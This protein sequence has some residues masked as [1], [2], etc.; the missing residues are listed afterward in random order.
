MSS[1]DVQTLVLVSALVFVLLGVMFFI[2]RTQDRS[3][4]GLGCWGSAFLLAA[5]GIVLLALRGKAP[6]WATQTLANSIL[7]LGHGLLYVGIRAFDGHRT[8]SWVVVASPLVWI[9]LCFSPGFNEDFGLRI[10]VFAFLAG[11]LQGA[12]ALSLGHERHRDPLP[13]RRITTIAFIVLTLTHTG[14]AILAGVLQVP[15]HFADIGSSWL[16]MAAVVMLLE[17]ILTGYLLLSLAKERA[18]ARHRREAE[19]D[20]LTGA[21]TRRAF[22]AEATRRLHADPDRGA[23]L[24]FDLDRFKAI[25]DTHGHAVGDRVL[26][27]FADLVHG[28]IRPADLFGRWGGEEFVLLLAEADFVGAHRT[29]EEIRR[30]FAALD[31]TDGVRSIGATVS[32]GI[33]LPAL[34]GPN[35]EALITCADAGLYAAKTGGRDRVEPGMV[36]DTTARPASTKSMI[37]AA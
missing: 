29:A 19:T 21:L 36:P 27:A 14:R 9:A 26:G 11:T 10:L 30:A 18:A 8:P 6:D 4:L 2:T 25:N 20:H 17:L 23:L 15:S 32:V 34:A 35:L 28:L 1:I 37:D 33:G 3:T 12:A 7:L 13:S 22:A 5:P 16:A 31:L 24:F